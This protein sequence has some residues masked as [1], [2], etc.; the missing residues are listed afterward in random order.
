MVDFTGSAGNP[1]PNPC[2][3]SHCD[4]IEIGCADDSAPAARTSEVKFTA[5]FS[6]TPVRKKEA[7]RAANLFLRLQREREL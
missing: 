5:V 3:G 4:D 2:L 6:S 1:A 7:L